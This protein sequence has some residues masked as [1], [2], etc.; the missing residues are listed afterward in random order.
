MSEGIPGDWGPHIL[1]TIHE[2]LE[3]GLPSEIAALK[4]DG[5]NEFVFPQ[6]STI[7]FRFPARGPLPPLDITWYDGTKNRAPRPKELAEGRKMRSCGKVIFS[8]DLT[9]MGGTHGDTLRIIPES[10]MKEMASQVPRITGRHSD[11]A[12]NFLLACQGREKT[13]SPFSIA[14]P[15]TQVFA[16]GCIAQRLGGTL[17]FDRRTKRITHN[18]VA[19]RL[20][21][22]PPPRKGWEEYYKLAGP[23]SS[24]TQRGEA[25][26]P[27]RPRRRE[28]PAMSEGEIAESE[29]GKLFRMGRQA[30]RFG[31]RE[32]AVEFYRKLT[33]E[34]PG[35]R[36]AKKA[37]EKLKKWGK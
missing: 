36:A 37:A 13:R 27:K 5:P 6:A 17:E 25:E 20:L 9:F 24:F 12:S 14:G 10:R 23:P 19:D 26:K 33:A 16:L 15:L 28:A 32:A 21:V 1:D 11:H 3:L 18:D 34:Y 30:E 22:G 2:F 29:A 31:Q 35:T 4:R 8:D 7:Q